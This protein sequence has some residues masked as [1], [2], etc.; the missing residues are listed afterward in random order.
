MYS[1]STVCYT[2]TYC[3]CSIRGGEL[4]D[5]LGQKDT[6]TEDEAV[7]FTRQLLDGLAYL[8]SKK[9]VHMDLKV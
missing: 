7:T 1:V 6:F 9:V 2:T 8:H 4:F 3:I 5:Y